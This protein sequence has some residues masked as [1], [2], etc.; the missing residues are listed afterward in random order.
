L[1]AR[2]GRHDGKR[3][4]IDRAVEMGF[5]VKVTA[6]VL[7][8]N[9]SHMP[10]FVRFCWDR[11]GGGICRLQ[12]SFSIPRGNAWQQRA[13]I[14]TFTEAAPWFVRCFEFGRT[15]GLRVESC[16]SCTIAPCVIPDYID[17]LDNYA[18]CR[19]T[20]L[21]P[22]R[23]KPPGRCEGC[24]HD[25][26]CPGVWDRYL[27]LYGDQELAAVRATSRPAAT[28]DDTRAFYYVACTTDGEAPF[29]TR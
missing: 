6:V 4:A 2:P 16:Q 26:I 23:K 18:D 29:V 28:P 8:P 13:L 17:H 22:E 27:E 24:V 3:A 10:E 1:V 9:L 19:G 7:K 14:P 11:W 21:E 5:K 12:L 20:V 25:V 15:V